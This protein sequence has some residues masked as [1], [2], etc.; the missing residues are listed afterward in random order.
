M[1]EN[2]IFQPSACLFVCRGKR[3]QG[4]GGNVGVIVCVPVGQLA[5][6]GLCTL[7]CSQGGVGGLIGELTKGFSGCAVQ[8]AVT[9]PTT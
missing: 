6:V 1:L 4:K 7:M 3:R 5:P 9:S 8:R 2:L